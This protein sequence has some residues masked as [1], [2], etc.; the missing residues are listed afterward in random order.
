MTYRGGLEDIGNYKDGFCFRFRLQTRLLWN[1]CAET[2]PLKEK[3]MNSI[4][5]VMPKNYTFDASSP[6]SLIVSSLIK[7]PF[8]LTSGGEP[9]PEDC[10][11]KEDFAAKKDGYWIVLQDWSQC[12]LACGGG[13]Q[14]LQ[15]MCMPPRNGGRGCEG[16]EILN[17]D[18]NIQP[19]PNV[20]EKESEGAA[21]PT[22]VKMQRLWSRGQRYEVCVI[23]EGDMDVLID[24]ET[25]FKFPPRYPCRVVLNNKTISIFTTPVK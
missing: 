16:E 14:F 18:C 3:W 21:N 24:S 15:R 17:R 10:T 8:N 12:S 13:K 2:L 19:C 4:Y 20:L 5:S 23:K 1:V 9:L 11:K 7:L 22:V 25:E 6:S